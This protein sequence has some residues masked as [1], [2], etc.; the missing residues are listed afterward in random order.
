MTIKTIKFKSINNSD[1][2]KDRE[3][4]GLIIAVSLF[5]AGMIIGAGL[6]KNSTFNNPDFIAL[7]NN[8][9][10]IRAKQKVYQLFSNSL[11]VNILFFS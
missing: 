10:Q 5:A 1:P 7:F 3:V 9:I 8:F 11:I 6:L 2:E 4:K